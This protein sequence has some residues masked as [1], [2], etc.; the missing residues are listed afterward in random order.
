MTNYRGIKSVLRS[1]LL[2]VLTSFIILLSSGC[3]ST[4]QG[5]N[6]NTNQGG[7]INADAP[8]GGH[9]IENDSYESADEYC[10]KL[11]KEISPKLGLT[12]M[13][14]T[15]RPEEFEFRI[16]TNLGSLGDAKMLIVRSSRKENHAYFFDIKRALDANRFR[17]EQ[18]ASPKSG[19]NRMLFEVRRQL[20]TPKG[21]VRDPQFDLDRDEGLILLE[22]LDK[23]EYRRVLYGQNTSFQDGKRLI[24]VCDYLS[25]E[26]DVD[27]DCNGSR[28]M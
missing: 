1:G 15:P 9:L 4:E 17:T 8:S 22:V 26:F 5:V 19:W 3:L 28:A 10:E 18:L 23:E 27:M 13:P 11:I 25:S 6:R 7:Q 21:L 12:L 24:E 16:W 14:K 2:S 20:T